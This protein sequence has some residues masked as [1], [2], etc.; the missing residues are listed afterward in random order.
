M[1]GRE[2]LLKLHSALY[3]AQHV[4]KTTTTNSRT[5]KPSITT[6]LECHTKYEY[7][8]MNSITCVLNVYTNAH[9]R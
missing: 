7:Y 8:I 4:R 1:K 3:I 2:N 9:G 5:R 6:N